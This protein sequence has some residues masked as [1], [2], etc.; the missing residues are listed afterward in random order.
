M[1]GLDMLDHVRL[2]EVGWRW[3]AVGECGRNVGRGRKRGGGG[4]HGIASGTRWTNVEALKPLLSACDAAVQG[5]Y[6]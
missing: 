4:G 5:G 2:S 1:R 3:E 6:E